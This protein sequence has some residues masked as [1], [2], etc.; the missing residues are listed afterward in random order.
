MSVVYIFNVKLKSEY[1]KKV[2]RKYNNY[3]PVEQIEKKFYTNLS[4]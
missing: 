1:I 4:K 3:L 2:Y